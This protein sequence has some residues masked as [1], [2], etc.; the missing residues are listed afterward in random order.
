MSAKIIPFA[1]KKKQL[2]QII[3]DALETSLSHKNP[4]VLRC[5]KGEIE[6]LLEKYFSSDS[7]EMTLMLP[8]DL[9]EDQFQTIRQNFK[10]IFSEHNERMVQRSNSIFLDLYLSRLEI[11]ELR[12]GNNDP[13]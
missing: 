4:Q 3:E 11:C 5:L 12:Y 9:T 6:K 7:P 10:Q 1:G 2:A 13:S 8:S